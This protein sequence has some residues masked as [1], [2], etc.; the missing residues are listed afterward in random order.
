MRSYEDSLMR[1]LH[2]SV[3]S[4]VVLATLLSILV[5]ANNFFSRPVKT[6]II[7]I[8]YRAG[9]GGGSPPTPTPGPSPTPV[10][11]PNTVIDSQLEVTY[12]AWILPNEVNPIRVV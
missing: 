4:A 9:Q 5:L 7:P 6:N 12:P 10:F 11:Q 2:A 8:P 3:L 1:L